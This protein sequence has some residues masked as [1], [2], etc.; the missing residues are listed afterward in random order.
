MLR[1]LI[2]GKQ[3]NVLEKG[4]TKF[5]LNTQNVTLGAYLQQKNNVVNK[6]EESE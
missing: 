6:L 3:R 1:N 5:Y 2:K 4:F